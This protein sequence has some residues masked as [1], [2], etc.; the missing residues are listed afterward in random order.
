MPTDN[1]T[2]TGRGA[3]AKSDAN[4]RSP[5]FP[6]IDLK[7]AVEKARIMFNKDGTSAVPLAVL[8][9]HWGYSQKSSNGT[10]AI[11]ALRKFGLVDGSPEVKLTRLALDI[12][13]PASEATR[14]EL[15]QRAA[16]LPALHKE[17]WDE[18]KGQLP[19]DATLEFRLRSSQFTLQGAKSFISQFKATLSYAGLTGG[20]S[21]ADSPGE[22]GNEAAG[23]GEQATPRGD[24]P[25]PKQRDP[26]K[27]LVARPGMNQDT[28]TLDEGQVVLQWPSQISPASYQDLKDWLDLMARRL[29]RAVKTPSVEN[30]MT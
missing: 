21:G 27:P 29:K 2:L 26:L 16:L 20:S 24:E 18:H 3:T 17:L 22:S 28:F 10:L 5:N 25:T 19:S 12:L 15:L 30:E 9:G 8:Q 11:S 1:Q 6:G 7:E 4:R 13:N 23:S 14:H